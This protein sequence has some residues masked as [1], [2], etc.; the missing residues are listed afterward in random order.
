MIHIILELRK[1]FD[2][3]LIVVRQKR[4]IIMMMSYFFGAFVLLLSYNGSHAFRFPKYYSDGM[5]MQANNANVWG[6]IGKILSKKK[7]FLKTFLNKFRIFSFLFSDE[8]ERGIPVQM[9]LQCMN[10]T[11]R[12]TFRPENVT[13]IQF[14]T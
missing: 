7:K 9:N 8:Y 14:Q 13:K 5:V 1:T 2:K 11:D 3:K 10:L 6:F 4:G 12:F